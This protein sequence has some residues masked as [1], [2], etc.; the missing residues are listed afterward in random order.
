MF[1]GILIVSLAK[2]AKFYKFPPF[3]NIM[4][5]VRQ[6]RRRVWVSFTPIHYRLTT[7]AKLLGYF[8]V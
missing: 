8:P 7:Y 4:V 6:L 1:V 3:I 2:S 5:A